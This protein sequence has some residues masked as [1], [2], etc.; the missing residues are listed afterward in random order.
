M[1]ENKTATTKKACEGC[2]C[3]CKDLKSR[4]RKLELANSKLEKSL[5]E[6]KE[7][8]EAA[9][10]ELKEAEQ[11]VSLC[12]EDLDSIKG[13]LYDLYRNTGNVD[14]RVKLQGLMLAI[15]SVR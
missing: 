14:R 8:L 12:D 1:A 9:Q 7:F 3:D 6:T 11:F 5:K 2:D 4:A 15:D 13:I 10:L